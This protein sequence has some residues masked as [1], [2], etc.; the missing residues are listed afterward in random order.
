ML[1]MVLMSSKKRLTPWK[2]RKTDWEVKAL[3]EEDP[4]KEQMYRSLA[5]VAEL[6]MD[7]LRLRDNQK[8][9]SEIAQR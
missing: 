1:E 9:Q 4:R 8:P 2:N 5:R 6:K 3:Q 7:E